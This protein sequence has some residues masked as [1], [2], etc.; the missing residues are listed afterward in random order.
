M[1]VSVPG[2][3]LSI[4]FEGM[5]T[6]IYPPEL[7]LNKANA[8]DTEALSLDLH[9]SISEGFVSSKFY[10][11]RDDFDTVNFPLLDFCL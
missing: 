8:S 9:I 7:Q 3:C 2:H 1:I 6:R 11:K 4:Y 10:D 5:V